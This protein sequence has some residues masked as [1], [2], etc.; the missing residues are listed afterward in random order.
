M[1]KRLNGWQ[2]IGVVLSVIWAIGCPFILGPLVNWNNQACRDAAEIASHRASA[3][4]YDPCYDL[5]APGGGTCF[6]KPAQ[7]L[8][9]S[10][11]LGN[12][13]FLFDLRNYQFGTGGERIFFGVIWALVFLLE[14]GLPIVG[15]WAVVYAALATG[16][17][18][19]GGF[20]AAN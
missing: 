17:W 12:Y 11:P 20:R 3:G 5:M 18:V 15:A 16:R 13:Q 14:A 4:E 6:R 19:R 8:C 7:A 2:R 9:L 1:A 10:A